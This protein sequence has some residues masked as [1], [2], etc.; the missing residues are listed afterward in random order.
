MAKEEP[1]L[2]LNQ[3]IVDSPYEEGVYGDGEDGRALRKFAILNWLDSDVHTKWLGK[4]TMIKA[5]EMREC[6]HAEAYHFMKVIV[7]KYI[8]D[9]ATS[10]KDPKERE[11]MEMNVLSKGYREPLEA[12]TI[13]PIKDG[14]ES[15]VMKRMKDEIRKQVEAE[16][17]NNA[18]AG[19]TSQEARGEF[20]D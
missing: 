14:E 3:H 10:I 5:G 15:P 7:D 16:M 13:T 20:E 8:F 6:G 17:R 1:K 18:A 4:D 12:K 19:V 11:K 2:D 9:S